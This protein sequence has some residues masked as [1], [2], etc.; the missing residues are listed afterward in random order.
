MLSDRSAA[1]DGGSLDNPPD[2]PSHVDTIGR[3]D[4]VLETSIQALPHVISTCHSGDASTSNSTELL[5]RPR[6]L[7]PT[8]DQASSDQMEAEKGL[9]PT[10]T[11]V[12]PVD[13]VSKVLPS[14]NREYALTEVID[15]K[16]NGMQQL[17]Q[18]SSPD[19]E[20][21]LE[22]FLGDNDIVSRDDLH[23]P[24]AEGNISVDTAA[25]ETNLANSGPSNDKI[26]AALDYYSI[27]RN[28]RKDHY[29]MRR[30]KSV[31]QWK[32][33]TSLPDL[34]YRG[35]RYKAGDV[36][37]ILLQGSAEDALAKIREIRDLAD[38]RKVISILWYFT[39]E[40]AKTYGCTTLRRWPK[41][42]SHMLTTM[43]QV[44]LWDTINGMVDE[45]ALKRVASG[46]ILDVCAKTCK[47]LES[48]AKVVKWIN[49]PTSLC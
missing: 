41:G 48:D 31:P 35:I 44:L 19:F 27:V 12:E 17:Q 30:D 22:Q 1:M 37:Y 47:I 15:R 16:D 38:G 43:L 45:N 11:P 25:T 7:E 46:E 49:E 23:S 32:S 39:A 5:V 8:S 6:L 14:P 9:S 29:I 3:E 18:A 34:D 13:Q 26:E 21:T 24:G 33:L 10:P 36:V 40:D 2:V 28:G 42:R 20:Y 4:A